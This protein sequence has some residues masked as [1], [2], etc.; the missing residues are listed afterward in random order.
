MKNIDDKDNDIT[1][2]YKIK[3]ACIKIIN[4]IEVMRAVMG[5]FFYVCFWV[6]LMLLLFSS[7]FF[8]SMSSSVSSSCKLWKQFHLNGL[9]KAGDVNLGGLFEVHYTSVFPEWT[10]SS[11]PR[12]PTCTG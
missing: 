2:A 12:Q 1:Y 10:F 4:R 11:E 3:L 9:Y 5:D 7:S 8:F 6:Y